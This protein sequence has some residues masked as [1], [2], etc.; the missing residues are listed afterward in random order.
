[1]AKQYEVS[2]TRAAL[3]EL[4]KLGPSASSSIIAQIRK[5]LVVDP[6]AYGEELHGELKGFF[7]LRVSGYRV[8]YQVLQQRVIV[9]V[10][11]VGKRN[12]GNVDN[13]YDWLSESLLKGRLDAWEREIGGAGDDE[14]E[15]SGEGGT[16]S[17]G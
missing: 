15:G 10:L 2:F 17:G 3:K 14:R 12:E 7:K 8:V 13:I 11:A 4:K 5:K 1:M 9:V 6:V 16:S